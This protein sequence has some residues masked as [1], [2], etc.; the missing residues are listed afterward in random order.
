MINL[1]QY[2]YCGKVRITDRNGNE[3]VGDAQEVTD[4]GE[5]SLDEP[6][7]NGITILSEGKLIEFY[8]SEILSIEKTG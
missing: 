7:E 1:W 6:A 4:A 2:E 3:F 8:G 5:R